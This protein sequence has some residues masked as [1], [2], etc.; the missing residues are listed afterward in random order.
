[1][2]QDRVVDYCSFDNLAFLQGRYFDNVIIEMNT[3]N[4]AKGFE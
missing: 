1:L 2:Q 4:E 3:L